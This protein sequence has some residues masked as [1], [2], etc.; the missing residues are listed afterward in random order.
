MICLAAGGIV[1]TLLAAAAYINGLPPQLGQ[2]LVVIMIPG[3]WLEVERSSPYHMSTLRVIMLNAL[4]YAVLIGL[5]WFL[6]R[7]RRAAKEKSVRAG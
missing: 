7:A 3:I 4:V 5:V 6:V 1:A 2:L